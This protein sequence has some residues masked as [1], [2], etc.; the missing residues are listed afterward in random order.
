MFSVFS[1]VTITPSEHPTRPGVSLDDTAGSQSDGLVL[2]TPVVGVVGVVGVPTPER[3]CTEACL[4]TGVWLPGVK[5]VEHGI[6]K[7]VSAGVTHGG[8]GVGVTGGPGLVPVV[9]PQAS[10]PAPHHHLPPDY[11]IA[12]PGP[13]QQLSSETKFILELELQAR[14]PLADDE[15]LRLPLDSVGADHLKH[16]SD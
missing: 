4:M 6:V 12:A 9:G 5:T 8:G 11:H 16:G 3:C 13:G 10:I 14:F 1:Q 2:V 15:T 7:V